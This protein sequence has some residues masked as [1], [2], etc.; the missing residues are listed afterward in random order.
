MDIGIQM[1]VARM[2]AGL[3]QSEAAR[4]IGVSRQ[5]LSNWENERTYPD[6]TQLPVMSRVYGVGVDEL[7]K[8]DTSVQPISKNE[9]HSIPRRMQIVLKWIPPILYGITVLLLCFLT[10]YTEIAPFQDK[11]IPGPS[12]VLWI[13]TILPIA[14]IFATIWI[15]ASEWWKGGRWIVVAV[16]QLVQAGIH[17]FW[18]Y[19]ASLFH[20]VQTGRAVDHVGMIAQTI[21]FVV[22]AVLLGI[23]I[24][25]LIRYLKPRVTHWL[26]GID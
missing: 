17:Y 4:L 6:V 2:N 24:G 9:T 21:S 10:W 18:L 12:T 7:L 20:V 16:I 11:Y 19:K 13:Y 1:K 26:K 14:S 3:T 25:T 22:I 15:C 5:T 23:G 8:G